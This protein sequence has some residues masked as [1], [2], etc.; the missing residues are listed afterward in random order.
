M[1]AVIGCSE[2][3][4]FGELR[5]RRGLLDQQAVQRNSGEHAAIVCAAV[6]S[7]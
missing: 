5:Q 7:P 6:P 1:R 3:R 2:C 4:R